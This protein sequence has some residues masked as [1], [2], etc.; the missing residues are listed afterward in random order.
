MKMEIIKLAATIVGAGGIGSWLTFKLGNRKQDV[1]EFS[2]IITEYKA[3]LEGFK[4]EVIE[5]RNEVDDVR[6]MLIA[7]EREISDLQAEL[8]IFKKKR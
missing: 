5:L 8:K 4:K 3:L 2:S 7:R 6:G 1:S